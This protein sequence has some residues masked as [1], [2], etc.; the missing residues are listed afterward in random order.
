MF[1]LNTPKLRDALLYPYTFNQ[2]SQRQKRRIMCLRPVLKF[3]L[4]LTVNEVRILIFPNSL[5][6]KIG[7]CPTLGKWCPIATPLRRH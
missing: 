7:L 2:R 1:P 3:Q 4:D 5:G 6:L